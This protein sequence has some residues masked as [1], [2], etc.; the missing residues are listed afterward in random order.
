MS[1]YYTLWNSRFRTCPTVCT[2]GT[3]SSPA[4][5][6]FR[7]WYLN[8]PACLCGHSC[9]N[10]CPLPELLDLVTGRT[11]THSP[12]PG[13]FLLL[14]EV[15]SSTGLRISMNSIHGKLRRCMITGTPTTL[16]DELHLVY[17][18]SLHSHPE[19]SL[20][21]LSTL[22]GSYVLWSRLR[23]QILSWSP[24]FQTM[25]LEVLILH[26]LI[27]QTDGRGLSLFSVRFERCKHVVSSPRRLHDLVRCTE[28]GKRSLLL[29][30]DLPVVLQIN[31]L[32]LCVFL[33]EVRFSLFA[34]LCP[35]LLC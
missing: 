6:D 32:V 14:L 33:H 16:I 15:S 30:A 9:C 4:D 34:E 18:N 1:L 3:W 26:C 13:A 5:D 10:L 35:P 2:T 17:L 29:R 24:M 11:C 25:K 8:F 19:F 20:L 31:G 28:S 22:I 27:L 7:L 23:G 21:R 12:A